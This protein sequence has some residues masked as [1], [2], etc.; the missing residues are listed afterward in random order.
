MIAMDD[1][2]HRRT[3]GEIVERTVIF[4]DLAGFTT[5]TLTHGDQDAADVAE[6]FTGL[7]RSEL[8]GGDQLVK[9]IGDAVMLTSPTPSVVQ[10][11][12][13]Q[14]LSTAARPL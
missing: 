3:S 10:L 5:T 11:G 14:P 6:R 1:V 12:V 4:I 9:S 8:E 13:R 2:A 7:A